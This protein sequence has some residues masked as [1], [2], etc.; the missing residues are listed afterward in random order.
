MRTHE[1]ATIDTPSHEKSLIQL[2]YKRYV[3]IYRFA[4]E[5][6][7]MVAYLIPVDQAKLFAIEG[8]DEKNHANSRTE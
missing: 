1:E 8:K 3:C 2:Y 6:R 5:I 7:F 4:C